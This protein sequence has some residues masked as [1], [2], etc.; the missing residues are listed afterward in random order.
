MDGSNIAEE[1]WGADMLANNAVRTTT[2]V[3][4]AAAKAATI[5][6]SFL[7]ECTILKAS[8]D[9]H[10]RATPMRVP[11]SFGCRVSLGTFPL[12]RAEVSQDL[13]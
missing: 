7:L 13:Q 10:S 4:T 11:L 5:A 12:S 3:R 1:S 9:S 2:N 6:A 8:T